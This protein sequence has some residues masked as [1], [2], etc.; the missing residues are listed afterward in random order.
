MPELVIPNAGAATET[1]NRAASTPAQQYHGEA[2][3]A[4]REPAFP[5]I[6]TRSKRPSTTRSVRQ[7][8]RSATVT[9]ASAVATVIFIVGFVAS[10]IKFREDGQSDPV[11]LFANAAMAAIVLTTAI[12]V[13]MLPTL[14]AYN[15]G[16][17][18]AVPICVINLFAGLFLLPWVGCLAWAL[19]SHVEESRQTVR[20]VRV[21]E[22]GELLDQ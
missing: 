7:T 15:R 21:N 4:G 14:I 20:I 8:R 10:L 5:E 18:N 17:R 19:S 22:R 16:H 12:A 9:I 3:R 1:T 11:R 2:N 13:Y 6:N